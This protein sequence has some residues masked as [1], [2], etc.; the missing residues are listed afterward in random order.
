MQRLE[1]LDA[2]R[3]E[4][5]DTLDAKAESASKLADELKDA[6]VYAEKLQAMINLK[7]TEHRHSLEQMDKQSQELLTVR[8]SLAESEKERVIL[9]KEMDGL[10]RVADLREVMLP[11]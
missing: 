2:V 4:L 3:D 5:Q 6:D 10:R 8:A 1:Y 11:L 7:A 9:G